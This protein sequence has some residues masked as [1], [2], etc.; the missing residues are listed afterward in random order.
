MIDLSA[1]VRWERQPHANRRGA[2]AT[3]APPHPICL[4]RQRP[5]GGKIQPECEQARDHLRGCR[6]GGRQGSSRTELTGGGGGGKGGKASGSRSLHARRR[7]QRAWIAVC[8]TIEAGR[9][10]MAQ[11]RRGWPAST[12]TDEVHKARQHRDRQ[13]DC[14]M[15]CR[16]DKP[17]AITWTAATRVHGRARPNQSEPAASRGPP[18]MPVARSAP[19]AVRAPVGAPPASPAHSPNSR[20]CLQGPARAQRHDGSLHSRRRVPGGCGTRW[21]RQGASVVAAACSQP[22]LARRRRPTWGVGPST[23]APQTRGL[24]MSAPPPRLTAAARSRPA[25]PPA[26]Q[27]LSKPTMSTA[28]SRPPCSRCAGET[29]VAQRVAF[30]GMHAGQAAAAPAHPPACTLPPPPAAA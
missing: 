3:A 21:G 14:P 6:R 8:C 27:V 2:G 16:G 28:Y 24:G 7:P 25:P 19:P 13:P 9:A 17:C 10:A 29:C 20:L 23:H 12:L 22:E 1:T 18:C 15:G 5:R 11:R 4:G 26:A 30:N